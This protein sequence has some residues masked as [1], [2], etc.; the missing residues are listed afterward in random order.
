MQNTKH[1][2]NQ[3]GQKKK[4]KLELGKKL[5]IR[6][7]S[8][9]ARYCRPGVSW[10]DFRTFVKGSHCLIRQARNGNVL[11]DAAPLFIFHWK[12]KSGFGVEANCKLEDETEAVD[13]TLVPLS[14]AFCQK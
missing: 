4:P 2:A 14:F 8:T 7:L 1:A 5:V 9:S 3:S 10:F 6:L 12:R 13:S 11:Y